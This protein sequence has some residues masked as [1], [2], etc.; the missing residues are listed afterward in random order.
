M[1]A[2]TSFIDLPERLGIDLAREL[3]QDIFDEEIF[4]SSK[5][6]YLIVFLVLFTCHSF[7]F[8]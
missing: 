1:G 5:F 3:A 7:V 4:L 2:G 6:Y 8:C